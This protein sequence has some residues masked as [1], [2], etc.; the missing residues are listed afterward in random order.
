MIDFSLFDVMVS[1]IAA[2][3]C[4]GIIGHEREKQKKAAGIRTHIIV[5]IG[6]CMVAL[7][8]RQ[9]MVSLIDELLSH[10]SLHGSLSLRPTDML[11]NV[12]T[13][14][15]F[16]GAGTIMV[17]K[18]KIEG[19][20]T[21][22][23]VWSVAIIGMAIGLG[24]WQIV[25]PGAIIIFLTLRI[26]NRLSFSGHLEFKLDISYLR[27]SQALSEIENLFEEKH[28]VTTSIDMIDYEDSHPDFAN[29]SLTLQL[30]K[31]VE[32]NNVMREL[33]AIHNIRRVQVF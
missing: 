14:V 16:L 23:S 21:A 5:C 18:G 30:P 26:V 2:L 1:L 6:A 31:G 29:I 33:G 27:K 28:I 24:S 10:D 32:I 22:A 8:Q 20:T 7:I 19:L 4:G 11:A 15:G 9:V 13:G 25:V 17:N 12:I 3:L